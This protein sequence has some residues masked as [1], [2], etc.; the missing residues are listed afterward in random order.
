MPTR[1]I[2]GIRMYVRDVENF[3]QNKGRNE[4]PRNLPQMNHHE[5]VTKE[6]H[7]YYVIVLHIQFGIL[8]SGFSLKFWGFRMRLWFIFEGGKI[9]TIYTHFAAHKQLPA[10]P[11]KI[12]TGNSE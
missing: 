9:L 12:E 3:G 1:G 4:I 5:K 2:H 10:I 7:N 11:V 8:D 6:S